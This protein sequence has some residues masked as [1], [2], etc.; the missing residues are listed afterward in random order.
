MHR[1]V[2]CGPEGNSEGKV[3]IARDLS[4]AGPTL[5]VLAHTVRSSSRAGA[6]LG[7]LLHPDGFQ[8]PRDALMV[9]INH[10]EIGAHAA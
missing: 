5:H 4:E 1:D 9:G 8:Q 7:R 2:D 6:E 3:I 10:H